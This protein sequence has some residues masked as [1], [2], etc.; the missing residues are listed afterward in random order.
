MR[1]VFLSMKYNLTILKIYFK[2]GR[3][4]KFLVKQEENSVQILKIHF[5]YFK[6]VSKYT[7]F[8]R[9]SLSNYDD[10]DNNDFKTTIGLMIKTTALHVHHAF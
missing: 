6:S 9:G 10:D 8:G 5:K 3:K 7:W 4:F 1:E 2:Q